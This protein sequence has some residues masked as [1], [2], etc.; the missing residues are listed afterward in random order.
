MAQVYTINKSNCQ[1][2][3]ARVVFERCMVFPDIRIFHELYVLLHRFLLAHSLYRI[4]SVPLCTSLDL[5]CPR[6]RALNVTLSC[7]HNLSLE[8]AFADVSRN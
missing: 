8:S 4:P 1:P 5:H 3:R 7:L 6:L 2:L